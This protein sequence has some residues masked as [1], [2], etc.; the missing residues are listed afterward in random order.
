MKRVTIVCSVLIACVSAGSAFGQRQLVIVLD[1]TNS[2]K[3]LRNDPD[4]PK[5]TR[6][7]DAYNTAQED[8]AFFFENLPG[9]LTGEAAIIAFSGKFPAFL[10]KTGF[11]DRTNAEIALNSIG[12]NDCPGG[13][14]NLADA[15]CQ[16]INLFTAVS[17]ANKIMAISSDGDENDSSGKCFGIDDPVAPFDDKTSWQGLVTNQL[18]GAPPVMNLRFWGAL[19]AATG[20]Q[21][22]LETGLPH[23][24]ASFEF[25]EF[26]A[27]VTG[28]RFVFQDDTASIIPLPPVARIPA[29]STWGIGIMGLMLL[30]VAKVYYSRRRAVQA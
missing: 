1:R 29:V 28:G 15:I 24:P 20:T 18:G 10:L 2:M 13:S 27:D 5:N 7:E 22:D 26:L 11:L 17:A 19:G 4:P 9:G 25:F 21:L 3:E 16:G 30:I 23:I 8:L 6:C 14:T 12:A